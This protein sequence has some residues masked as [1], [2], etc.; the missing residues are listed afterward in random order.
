[1]FDVFWVKCQAIMLMYLLLYYLPLPSMAF[2]AP[3][4]P[5]ALVQAGDPPDTG[6]GRAAP[7]RSQLPERLRGYRKSKGQP[8]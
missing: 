7:A 2:K 8:F 1:V 5:S 3:R 4:S 6:G